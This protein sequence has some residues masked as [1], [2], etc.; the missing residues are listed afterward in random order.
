MFTGTIDSSELG[1]SWTVG[2]FRAQTRQATSIIKKWVSLGQICEIVSGQYVNQYVPHDSADA[3]LF[4][5]VDSVRE[6]VPNLSDR[7]CEYV[8]IKNQVQDRSRIKEG[9]VVIARTGTLGKAFVATKS[10]AGSVLSQHLTRLT[11][12]EDAQEDLTPEFICLALNSTFG[13]EQLLGVGSGSTRL[14]ITHE[15][16]STVR[17]PILKK[18]LIASMTESVRSSVRGEESALKLIFEAKTELENILPQI[19]SKSSSKWYSIPSKDLGVLW[20][21]SMY[22]KNGIELEKNILR[23]YETKPLNAIAAV[24]RGK[25][26]KSSDYRSHGI[27]FIRTTSLMNNGLDFFPDHY[28][29][30]ETYKNYKQ[31]IREGDLLVSI[32]GK[33]GS[34]AILQAEWPV[35]FKN[36]IEGIRLYDSAGVNPY[37]VYL[38]F[39]TKQYQELFKRRTVV[40]ATIPGMASR[41]RE[42]PIIIGRNNEEKEFSRMATRISDKAK[43]A[44]QLKLAAYK[45]LHAAKE[46][47]E[48]L[49]G[50]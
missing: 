28:A 11:L 30:L 49:M 21:A 29:D 2:P 12:K 47:F 37:F 41:L 8:S 24:F 45:N 22:S 16:L 10:L 33:I 50:F 40:Q 20:T 18:A 46:Q 27:P 48:G 31:E 36:H 38:L 23:S 39:L 4:L 15:R 19:N 9:D 42:I 14:E 3:K 35:V 13:K 7:D 25:G 34:V 17:I 43:K 32:E 1:N 5:R 44:M 26:T 6:F